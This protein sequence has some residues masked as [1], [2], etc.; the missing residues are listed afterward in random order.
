VIN[1]H[2]NI[3][4]FLVSFLINFV[5]FN[6]RQIVDSQL[7]L[8]RLNGFPDI[9]T[10]NG[11]DFLVHEKVFVSG[12]LLRNFFLEAQVLDSLIDKEIF[13]EFFH[14]IGLFLQEWRASKVINPS[15]ELA[16]S[17]SF[18]LLAAVGVVRFGMALKAVVLDDLLFLIL[19]FPFNL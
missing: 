6:G 10:D 17:D 2:S 3:L 13:I 15:I 5:E 12:K 8:L 7:S 14:K 16:L 1:I 19:Q 9:V 18:F 11:P 4:K